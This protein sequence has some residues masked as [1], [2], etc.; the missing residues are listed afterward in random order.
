MEDGYGGYV[1]L[2]LLGGLDLPS[3]D[4]NGFSDPYCVITLGAQTCQTR[5]IQA[6]L[7]P[8]WNETFNFIV[9]DF[10]KGL[11]IKVFDKDILSDDFLGVANIDLR[12]QPPFHESFQIL[13]LKPKSGSLRV[14]IRCIDIPRPSNERIKTDRYGFVTSYPSKEQALENESRYNNNNQV[15]Q[16]LTQRL[17]RSCTKQGIPFAYKANYWI[18]LSS[19]LSSLEVNPVDYTNELKKPLPKSVYQQ[20]ELDLPRTFPG[21]PIFESPAGTRAM[22]E[23][24]HVCALQNPTIGYCQSM[25]FVVAVLLLL[26]P[27][28]HVVNI[29]NILIR[30]I[31]PGYWTHTMTGLQAD[32]KVIEFLISKNLT[33]LYQ[34]FKD[35][36][37]DVGTIS[38]AWLLTL[39]STTFPICTTLRL[40]DYLFAYGSSAIIKIVFC[41]FKL[42]KP[43]LLQLSDLIEVTSFL[44][45]RFKVFN[46]WDDLISELNGCNIPD[47]R[48][49]QLQKNATIEIEK[50]TKERQLGSLKNTKFT[51]EELHELYQHFSTHPK[52]SGGTLPTSELFNVLLHSPIASE[53][54]NEW[55]EQGKKALE[56]IFDENSDGTISFKEFCVSLAVYSRGSREEKMKFSFQVY[57]MDKSGSIEKD[58][59]LHYLMNHYKCSGLEE[60]KTKAQN[61]TD[62]IFSKYDENQDGKLSFKEFSCAC[63]AEPILQHVLGFTNE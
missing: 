30:D 55:S 34:H 2:Q 22:R 61:I 8:E 4:L 40:W 24:L 6:N 52:S 49:T 46:N 50:R 5:I 15:I 26:Y 57:D 36:R 59:M 44:N 13:P 37:I 9:D 20:I 56:K 3:A 63:E 32:I 43:K 60:E 39:F 53:K 21:N 23:V 1:Q 29:L 19:Q 41:I 47:E 35:L 45:E 33:D 48:I 10:S 14:S 51:L 16:Y 11:E 42:Y 12:N 17:P 54:W 62:I 25:S 58:E 38:T 7:N 28:A 18:W 27:K 31:V